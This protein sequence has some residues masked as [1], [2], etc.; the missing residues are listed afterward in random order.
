MTVDS[1]RSK[2]TVN[3]GIVSDRS[4]GLVILASSPTS[5]TG[6]KKGLPL[7]GLAPG[8]S[9]LTKNPVIAVNYK[10]CSGG[11]AP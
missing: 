8:G 3:I 7:V 11:L 9:S 10:A 2:L 1:V 4:T 6:R 5:L